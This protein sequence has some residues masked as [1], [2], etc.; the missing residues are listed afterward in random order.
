MCKTV[1]RNLCGG[2]DIKTVAKEI[3]VNNNRG[4][5]LYGTTV[6]AEG[7][8][9]S[10]QLTECRDR[11]VK[12]LEILKGSPEAMQVLNTFQQME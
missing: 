7:I 4:V 8:K 3:T 10:R 6:L 9:E 11:I 12:A 2:P 5:V 1:V